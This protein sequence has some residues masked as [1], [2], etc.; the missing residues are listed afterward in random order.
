MSYIADS[1][2]DP[3]DPNKKDTQDPTAGT[4]L[5]GGGSGILTG[6]TGAPADSQKPSSSGSFTNLQSYLDANTDQAAK[7]GSDIS[8]KLSGEA[9]GATD[10]LSADQSNFSNQVSQGGVTPDQ[11]IVDQAVS[12]PTAVAN[13]PNQYSQ[14]Q[15]Q[16]NAQYTGPKDLSSQ[17]DFQDTTSKFNKAS[18]DL[19]STQTESGRQGLLNQVYG[20]PDYNQ[21]EQNLDQLLLENNKSSQDALSGT[22]NQWRGISDQLGTAQTGAQSLATQRAADTQ[23]AQQYA[24]T[25]LGQ[26]NTTFQ[27][28]LTSGLASAQKAQGDSYQKIK[29]DIGSNSL[30]PDEYT[31][32]GLS[33][34]QAVYN[35]DPTKYVSQ[36]NPLTLYNYANPQQYAQ[37]AALAKLSGQTNNFLPEQDASQAGTNTNPYNFDSAG[38]QKGVQQYQDQFNTDYN[39]KNVQPGGNNPVSYQDMQ[40]FSSNKNFWVSPT[41]S[42]PA[43]GTYHD[44]AQKEL[45]AINTFRSGRGEGTFTVD[46]NGQLVLGSPKTIGTATGGSGP[47]SVSGNGARSI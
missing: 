6:G 16:Y 19:T 34:G 2:V 9:K 18:Q 11:N 15:N 23:T 40:N 30:T 21:G 5:S 36:A 44:E 14:F 8:S 4:Q 33:T 39:T 29:Q 43:S 47:A 31:K 28:N 7:E 10:Q 26:A 37:A 24:Q 38:F 13:D 41:G 27:G 45:D 25:Q 3:N 42:G 20:R 46:A 32:L 12:N 1:N 22:Y 17:S 35:V